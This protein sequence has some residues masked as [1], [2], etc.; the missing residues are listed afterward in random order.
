MDLKEDVIFYNKYYKIGHK[1]AVTLS[2]QLSKAL[3]K[4]TTAVNNYNRTVNESEG[5]YYVT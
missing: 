2:T 1:R 4:V 5:M 3:K